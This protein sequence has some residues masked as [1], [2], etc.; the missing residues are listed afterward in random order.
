VVSCLFFCASGLFMRVVFIWLTVAYGTQPIGVFMGVAAPAVSGGLEVAGA[1]RCIKIVV[2]Y[3]L[4][5]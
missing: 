4:S 3:F 2:W 1:G 5:A